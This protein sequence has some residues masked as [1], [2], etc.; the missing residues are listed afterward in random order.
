VKL[1]CRLIAVTAIFIRVGVAQQAAEEKHV[2][3]LV[4]EQTLQA[5][6]SSPL[7]REATASK[8]PFVF[9]QHSIDPTTL[10][11]SLIDLMR[12][13]DE[14]VLAGNWMH[15]A[16]A[17]S[18]SGHDAI[19]YFDVMV[20][21]SWKGTHKTGDVLTYG[22]PN[23]VICCEQAPA[24]CGATVT[25]HDNWEPT[26]YYG[27]VVLFLRKDESGLVDGYRLTGGRGTQGIFGIS[28]RSGIP[29]VLN[30]PLGDCFHTGI[31]AA[32][33]TIGYTPFTEA[34]LPRQSKEFP[35]CQ[36]ASIQKVYAGGCAALMQTADY[37][38]TVRDTVLKKYDGMPVSRL[39]KE[40]Q[41]AADSLAGEPEPN[42]SKGQ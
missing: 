36:D 41:S 15:T 24:A 31:D 21:R 1:I 4:A 42:N 39:L 29:S 11:P 10:E 13:S 34:H 12:R 5:V 25:G 19:T 2:K 27:M 6:E 8:Q 7:C 23:G 17:I 38:V 16:E 9:H 32:A 20:L 40:V 30:T 26:G 3:D 28:V 33:C 14:V 37:R 18:P 35:E 22:L